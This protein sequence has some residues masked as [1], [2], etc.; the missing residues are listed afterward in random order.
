M[1]VF[2]S[3][4]SSNLT[5]ELTKNILS[6]VEP[7]NKKNICKNGCHHWLLR[8]FFFYK[9][10]KK[11]IF[12]L[13]NTGNGVSPNY[14]LP[15]KNRTFLKLLVTCGDLYLNELSM[16]SVPALHSSSCLRPHS[17]CLNSVRDLKRCGICNVDHRHGKLMVQLR[18]R[19]LA[20]NMVP[21]NK[22][23]NLGNLKAES[24]RKKQNQKMGSILLIHQQLQF[25]ETLFQQVLVD[26]NDFL[27]S[28][29]N[30]PCNFLGREVKRRQYCRTSVIQK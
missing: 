5:L 3:K 4:I 2:T 12:L 22:H 20:L 23:T 25:E 15:F 29:I 18:S 16:P 27:S 11:G 14:I 19:A 21:K 30:W 10:N 1:F 9:L 28:S 8:L 17:I 6:Y 26:T 24:F 13:T 7:N